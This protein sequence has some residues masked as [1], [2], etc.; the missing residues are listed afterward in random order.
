MQKTEVII[1]GGGIAGLACAQSLQ[2][3]DVG[4][5]LLESSDAWGGRV[6]T[7]QVDGFLL[8]RGFQVLLTA[9]PMARDLLDFAELDLKPFYPGAL[10]RW[11]S[12]FHRVAD[13]WRRPWDAIC[14]VFSPI[15]TL[16]D[17]LRVG[18]LRRRVLRSELTAL[19]D[20]PNMS[21]LDFLRAQGFSDNMIDRF[22]RPFYSGVFLE[23]D[24]ATSS[25]MLQFVFRMFATG[26]A[27]LPSNG[28]GA[29]P[30]HMAASLPQTSIRL[31]SHVAEIQG[32]TV[33][34]VSGE[35]FSAR[36]IVV[37]T[38]AA[39]A[40]NFVPKAAVPNTRSVTTV[41]FAAEKPPIDQP[42][43]VLNA[44]REGPV[45]NLCVPSNTA[46]AYAPPGSSLISATVVQEV[47]ANDREPEILVR[48]HLRRW[49]GSA[50]DHWRHLRTYRIP[51]ALPVVEPCWAPTDASVPGRPGLFV[52]GDYCVNPSLQGAM[53]SGRLVADGLI[54][55][56]ETNR[57]IA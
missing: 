47:S 22:F 35:E 11:N 19:F 54:R 50:V 8:D 7:D 29:I 30:Q 20:L 27:A 2:N 28:I 14:N 12:A 46:T 13:P 39:S 32:K 45:N 10:V 44:E 38:D 26:N 5:T 33:R 48:D 49:F 37:A 23:A 34:L 21:S 9:Y 42:I 17:K 18:R 6:R 1:V 53:V 41:Y 40:A 55:D 36:A 57:Q 56:L 15:G 24:L 31:G 4:F 25:R 16:A 52:C 3:H 51:N 43:L